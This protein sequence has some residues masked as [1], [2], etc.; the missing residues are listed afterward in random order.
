MWRNGLSLN[1]KP[2]NDGGIRRNELA[3]GGPTVSQ[4]GREAAGLPDILVNE[5]GSP[6]SR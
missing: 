2:S 5:F 4:F 1:K 6:E 3:A